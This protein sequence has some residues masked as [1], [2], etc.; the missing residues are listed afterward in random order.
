MRS[1]LISQF[2]LWY[3]MYVPLPFTVSGFCC[4]LFFFQKF[5]TCVINIQRC[6]ALSN[7]S[8]TYSRYFNVLTTSRADNLYLISKRKKKKKIKR[9][10][11][12]TLQC[13]TCFLVR[14]SSMD[15]KTPSEKS[16]VSTQLCSLL[17]TFLNNQ[18]KS[19]CLFIIYLTRSRNLP[20]FRTMLTKLNCF[21]STN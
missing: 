12:G 21:C 6:V 20:L 8:D 3:V 13:T 1:W 10:N 5:E 17:N 19:R 15:S 7:G 18:G 14:R 4:W 11:E 16:P 9:T 2:H